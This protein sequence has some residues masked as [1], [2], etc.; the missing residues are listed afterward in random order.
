MDDAICNAGLQLT[1]PDGTVIN[2]SGD[3][4]VGCGKAAWYPS[5][6]QLFLN[7]TR[8]PCFFLDSDNTNGGSH[9]GFKIHLPSLTAYQA[10]AKQYG[11]H[12]ETWCEA[13]VR[14]EMIE[15]FDIGMQI[16]TFWPRL[17]FNEDH[18]DP[19]FRAVTNPSTRLTERWGDL[20][21][22]RS[23]A[24]H[25]KQLPGL[26]TRMLTSRQSDKANSTP[27]SRYPANR[28]IRTIFPEHSVEA[29]CNSPLSRGPSTTSLFYKQHCD[30][31]T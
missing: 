8:M 21:S 26:I 28:V 13:P 6:H 3:M 2:M 11:E 24:E 12:L 7:G 17:A 30:M 5:S 23:V 20:K 22:G 29:V 19:D 27:K 18:T 1:M 31:T 10:R 14:M 9:Q 4:V 15:S 16:P 25:V